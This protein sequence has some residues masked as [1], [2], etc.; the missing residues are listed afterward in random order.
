[1]KYI[2]ILLSFTWS[3]TAQNNY[4]H[5]N[6][7]WEKNPK[8]YVPTAE[9]KKSDMVIVQQ[10]KINEFAYDADGQ[11]I[12][13]ETVH[14]IYHVN[15]TK[16]IDA[17]NKGYMALG[18]ILE[19]IDLKARCIT[20]EN[21]VLYLNKSTV[22]SVDNLD[23]DGAYKIFAIDGVDAGCDVEILY[24]NKKSFHAYAYFYLQPRSPLAYFET[25]IISPKNLVFETKTYNGLDNFVNEKND[26]TKNTWVLIKKNIPAVEKEKYSVGK[27]GEMGYVYQLAY[28]MDRKKSKIYTWDIISRE[29]YTAL[30]A[31][32]KN[33]TKLVEKILDKNKISKLSSSAEKAKA[34]DSYIK[35]T[36]EISESYG[37]LTFE[38]G[39]D[40]KK[41]GNSNTM[42][43]YIGAL[44]FMQIPFELILAPERS[45]LKFDSKFPSYVYM[46]EY[47]IY[48]PETNKY[49]SPL[50]LY[51][52]YGFADP[53]MLSNEG[54]FIKEVN[55][56]D[57]S[58]STA[59]TKS[60]STTDYK[61]SYHNSDVKAVLDFDN[62][63]A[64]MEVNQ[65]IAGY[66]AYY[67]QPIY[68]YLTVEQKEEL[69]KNY[70]LT[71][72]SE[73]VKDFEVKGFEEQDLF[74]KPLLIKFT[75]E[76]NDF[77]E[78]AGNKFIFK[79]GLLIGPQAELYQEEKRK[80]PAQMDYPHYLSRN[81]EINIPTGF[82]ATNLKD[83]VI[84]KVCVLEGQEIASFKSSYEIKDNKILIK[85]YEDYRAINYPL[86]VFEN[87]KAVINAAADFNKKNIIFEKI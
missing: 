32:E 54:L 28:N 40:T 33:E 35:T 10:K 51:S 72:N 11:A 7:S 79:A 56:G 24:I 39:L 25:R 58:S 81:L 76:Q 3:L 8:V 55:I 26:T 63:S 57:I 70:Y 5:S 37:S 38:K 48:F 59:K 65:N 43:L 85:V 30:Y 80:T 45:E 1:M 69:H 15:S 20:P 83:L 6:Y 9:E 21:K 27:A 60:I 23:D 4:Y 53:D 49:L 73:G 22:K 18:S 71:E 36:Y 86:D 44:K 75:M 41:M 13:Y 17:V 84:D 2:V 77:L 19:E 74:V 62:K 34:L 31:L 67:L 14:I 50:S 16:A 64:K 29:Y 52:R 61:D 42:K 68:R 46:K 82:K 87:F 78:S 12:L 47:L 66:N